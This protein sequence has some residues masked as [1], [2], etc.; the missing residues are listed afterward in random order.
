MALSRLLVANRG[1]VA[2]RV[3]RTG[4]ALGLETVA[5]CPDDDADALHV[6]RAD[7][8]VRL[9]GSGP[10][11]YLAAAA[12]V[13]AAEESGADAVHPGYGF[14]SESADLARRCAPAGATFGGPDPAALELFGDKSRARRQGAELGLPVLEATSG[15]T[16]L[17]A[18]RAFLRGLGEGGAVMVKALAGGGGRG[19]QPV[20]DE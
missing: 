5:V 6:R 16:D 19:L 13:R 20:R 10:A 15:P 2:V 7:R 11:A 12:V 8:A 1:E 17:A 4:A 9:P 3:L 14:L 18:A